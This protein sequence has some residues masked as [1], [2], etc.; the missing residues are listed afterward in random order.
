MPAHGID[1]TSPL[2][3]VTERIECTETVNILDRDNYFHANDL[4]F[5]GS[6]H[7]PAPV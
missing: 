1:M 3:G 5:D 6:P 4:V 7:D 2:D